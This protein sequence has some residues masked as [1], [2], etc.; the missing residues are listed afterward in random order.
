MQDYSSKTK[1]EL[2]RICKERNI[3]GY[4][5][6]KKDELIALLTPPEPAQLKFIDLF[7][8]VGGFHQALERLGAKCVL[9]CDIDEKCR[10]IYNL[11]YG[12]MP[13]NDVTTIDTETM[14]DF[15][16][17]CAGFPCQPFSNGGNK[18]SF[19]D[20]R[21]R[22]FDEIIRIAN[23]K[24]PRFM[25]LENVKHIK[26]VSEGEVFKYI[27]KELDESG[28]HVYVGELS[29]HQLGIP[30]QRERVIFTCIRKD[31]YDPEKDIK[32]DLPESV[33][34]NFES[35]IDRDAP[36]K[37][38][39]TEKTNNILEVWDEMV[40]HVEVGQSLSPVILCKEFKNTYT[41]EEFSKLPDWKQQYIK[42]NR[43]LYEKYKDKWDSWFEE[44]KEILN[45]SEV[46]GKL[47]WQAGPKVEN[48][49]IFNHFIQ[50]RQSGIRVKKA[51]YFPTLVAIVQIPI[52]GKEKRYLTPRECARL[53]SFPDT[54][55]LHS[56]DKIAYKQFGN[57]VNVEVVHYVMSKVLNVYGVLTNVS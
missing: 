37:Y 31:I 15:D 53:Q 36:E 49:S 34:C 21:G 38:T 1:D 4:S 30:Q 9:A 26:K 41:E 27:L 52:Y 56:D 17:L 54:F 50:L 51:R 57:A 39:I 48:D 33:E 24:K 47:E 28:Y 32:I 44:H 7:C 25:F 14:P 46:N 40:R 42:G 3:K 8:G 23:A 16:I 12:I 35:I 20:R 55:I 19:D 2:K 22:L 11:N 43:P 6:K 13:H 10:E 29:P 18:K 5:S 45:A